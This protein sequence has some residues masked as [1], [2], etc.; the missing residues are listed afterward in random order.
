MGSF[1]SYAAKSCGRQLRFLRSRKNTLIFICLFVGGITFGSIYAVAGGQSTLLS[2]IILNDVAVQ[3]SRSFRQLFMKSIIQGAAILLYLYFCSNCSKGKPLIHL[4]PLF[5]GLSAGASI[6]TILAKFS[7]SS[8]P[9][10][11]SCILVPK[12]LQAVLLLSACGNALKIST[13]LFSD[14][15]EWRRTEGSFIHMG[16]YGGIFLIFSLM[17]TILIFTFRHLLP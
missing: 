13:Q 3:A 7:I 12:F 11:L 10:I 6:T 1:L 2:S 14:P 16:L 5:L 15:G 17:E 8:F 4:V 9:Y